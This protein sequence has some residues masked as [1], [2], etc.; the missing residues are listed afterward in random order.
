M[1]QMAQKGSGGAAPDRPS[2]AVNTLSPAGPARRRSKG[3]HMKRARSVLSAATVV[4]LTFGTLGLSALS[5]NAA[6]GGGGGTVGSGGGTAGNFST[7]YM[8]YDKAGSGGNPDQGYMQNS[9]QWFFDNSGAPASTSSPN[10]REFMTTACNTALANAEARKS[11]GT[12]AGTSRVVGMYWA[13][14]ASSVWGYGMVNRDTFLTDYNRWVADGNPGVLSGLS[15]EQAYLD[16]IKTGFYQGYDQIGPYDGTDAHGATAVCIALNADEPAPAN[17]SLT[18]TTDKTGTFDMAGSTAPVSDT[19]HASNGGSTIK[20]NVN[21]NVILHWDGVDGNPKQVSKQVSIA[22]TG[23]TATPTF[24]P[25]DFGWTA[26]PAGQFWFDV[27]VGKQGSM[28]AAVD[29]PDRDPRETW[30][31][32]PAKPEK[33]LTV[34]NPAKPLANDTVLA[35]GMSYDARIVAYPNGYTS[36]MTI[37]DVIKSDK[38]FIGATDKDVASAAYVLD[39]AGNKVP[40]ATIKIDRST[41]GQVIVSGRV[42]NIPDANQAGYTLVVPTYVLPTNSDY[43]IKDSSEVCYADASMSDPSKCLEGNDEQ[44]RKVTPAPDKVWVLDANGALT[45]EDPART[46]QQNADQKVFLPGD[47]VSAVVNGS[48]HAKLATDLTKYQL[49]DDWTKAAQ[50]VDFSDASKAKVFYETAPGSGKYTDVTGQFDVANNGTVTTATAK[51]DFLKG[52]AGQSGDR[53]TK[54]VISGKFRTDYDTNG[55]TVKLLN[56]GAEVWNNETV[57]TNEPPVFTWTP[58]PNKQVLGSAEESGDHAHDDIN[59]MSVWPGQKL[60]YS[61]GVDLRVPATTARGV[62]SLAVQDVY[63]PQ[64]TPDKSSVEFWDSRDPKNPKP[65]PRNAY[66][67]SWDEA[68]HSF[69]ATFTDEW[70]KANVTT[71]GANSEWSTQG[72][73]SMRFTGTVKSDTKPGTS[74]KN[75][76]FEILNGVST[77]TEIPTVKIPAPEPHKED[78]NT[79][80]QNIDGKTVVQGDHIL[81]RLTLDAM[82][83]RDKL[84]YN[85]HKLGMTDDYDEQYLD[86][87]AAGIKI[88]DKATGADVTAKFN[89]QVKDGT[90][91]VFA[92]Q[93]DS[94]DMYGEKLP[95]DPQPTDLKAYADSKIDALK[96]PVIDQNLMGHQYWITLDTTV[97]KETD[98]YV[99]KN[100]AVQNIENTLMKTEIVSNPLKD[101]DPTKDVVVSEQTGENSINKS[102]VKLNSTFNYRL[103][104]SEIPANRAYGAKDWSLSDKFDRVHDQYTGVWAIYANDDLYDGQTLLVKK[105]ALLADSAGHESEA[106]K[107][108]FDV[109]F[110]QKS[111]TFTAKATQKYLDLVNTRGDLAQAFSVYTQMIRIAPAD[112]VNNQT[113]ET[114]NSVERDSNIVWTKTP[115]NPAISIVKF[116]LDQGQE[117]GDHDTD[118]DADALS[119]DGLKNGVKVGFHITNTGDVSLKNVSLADETAA[120]TAGHVDDIACQ[121]PLSATQAKAL[122]ATAPKTQLEFASKV[123]ADLKPGESFD[124]VGTLHDVAA[125]QLHGDNATTTGES[126]YTG[127]KVSASDPWY[128]KAPESPAISVVKFTLDQGQKKGD[129]DTDK[130]ADA[131]SAEGLKNGVKVGFH[132][133]NTGDVPLKNLKLEDHTVSGTN[134]HVD[135]ID[136]KVPTELKPGA[137]FDCVGT[138]HGLAAEQLHGDNATATGESVY[139]GKKVQADDPWYAKAPTSPAPGQPAPE[140]PAQGQPGDNSA[141][142]NGG[143]HVD[144]PVDGPTWWLAATGGLAGAAGLGLL[145]RFLIQRVRSRKDPVTVA[146]D[147]AAEGGTSE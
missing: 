42:A 132:V 109:T 97:K 69:T 126:V 4:G 144:S 74:V 29:T 51:A 20:E 99:I 103:N 141:I 125:G 89:V 47:A 127:K 133:T 77:A 61:V 10:A 18:L 32:Q 67:L 108:L 79:D 78:L 142:G 143:H 41:A 137:S 80:L 55:A 62:K 60:E 101:I 22:N 33:S 95:G 107:G 7:H 13:S 138:L 16:M 17:Y 94:T 120:G 54:L 104:S 23:D 122:G 135:D 49:T 28:N 92:K 146:A 84:A 76:A 106:L 73:L 115:E 128:A 91:Y 52:T 85:V 136:C 145:V 116:T 98:G 130:D 82:P 35:S 70:I 57:Q 26:W 46:N 36:A 2:G 15:N 34:G 44:T 37:Y 88:T 72:W 93:V 21:G 96:T 66:T 40:G 113:L 53:K 83:S 75:Q 131:L 12:P 124:C 59:G 25:A 3:S 9:V 110:D 11:P 14:D 111:Y 100:Q 8:M 117:K 90:A 6:G 56:D 71:D 81:Y 86:L 30:V 102:E 114:Y 65:V 87:D 123:A 39:P 58:D 48:V 38:V 63:D 118:K 139:S 129:H 121:V 5:A 1:E 31:A 45:A 50:Y 105:G 119:A 68:T 24:T 19:I 134:G 27:Q 64:F 112:K 43:D 140:N 147:G